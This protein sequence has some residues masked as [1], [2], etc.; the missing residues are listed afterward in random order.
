MEIWRDIKGYEGLYQVSNLGN[1]KA[2]KKNHIG[3]G[4][5]Q[6][7]DEH[8]LKLHKIIVWGKERVQVTLHK[9]GVKKY[10]IVSRLVYE[11]FVGK[12]PEGVQV[13][14]IDEDPSNNFVE[15]LNLMTPK[16]N[17]NWGTRNKR[18]S[19]TQRNDE[20]KSK[21]IVQ[22]DMTTNKIIA[23]YPSAKEAQRITGF[24]QSN[25]SNCCNGGYIWKGKWFNIY[26]AYG[27]KWQY[28][29]G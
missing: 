3:K 18:I 23:T 11:A 10:P 13:N 19:K 2:L 21:P 1:V 26:S 22:I 7:D 27:Y 6:F 24:A 12:I 4:R 5:N 20:N 29:N 8:L 16:E 15:N 28:K 14:H 17:S 9:N 25:I